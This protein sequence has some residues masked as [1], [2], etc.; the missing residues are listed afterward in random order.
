MTKKKQ[1]SSG[2]KEKPNGKEKDQEMQEQKTGNVDIEETERENPVSADQF[3]D[4]L[5]TVKQEVLTLQASLDEQRD[6]YLRLYAEFENFKKRS[7]KEKLDL[8]RSAAQDTL[9]AILPILDDFDRAKQ[10]SDD[11]NTN[12]EFSEGVSLVYNRLYQVLTNQ[13][14]KAMETDGVSFDPELHEAVSEIEVPSKDMKGKILDTIEKGYY[15]NDKII[16][17]AKVVVGK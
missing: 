1:D 8:L 10:V 16:R 9:T 5:E 15:L 11:P 7:F 13:G 2:N 6:K 17:H 4:E 12:E 14:L 3:E